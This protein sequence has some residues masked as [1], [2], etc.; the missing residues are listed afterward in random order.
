MGQ[1]VKADSEYF[2]DNG[3]YVGLFGR[4][5]KEITV[6]NGAVMLSCFELNG[7]KRVLTYSYENARGQNFLVFAFD[8]YTMSEHTFKQYARG[9]QI[10][11][12]ILSLGKKLPASMRGNPDCY[13][14]CKDSEKG[15]AV[16]IGNFFTDECMNTTV[17]LDREYSE[18]EFINC[19][20]RLV[21]DRVEID[22][23]APY[24]CVGFELK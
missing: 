24:A 13:M 18:I 10:E 3:R 11:N 16:F 9:E 14:I 7:E 19:S 2:P 5:V 17:L 22:Y 21:G 6:K 12:W 8:G 15:R 4:K 23:I 20:G 1:T